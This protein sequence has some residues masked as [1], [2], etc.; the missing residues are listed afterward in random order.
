[1]RLNSQ[2]AVSQTRIKPERVTL[3]SVVY[4]PACGLSSGL[5]PDIKALFLS[6]LTQVSWLAT[7][8][9]WERNTGDSL[10][11]IST[12]GLGREHTAG[13]QTHTPAHADKQVLFKKISVRWCVA[14]MWNYK[15]CRSLILEGKHNKQTLFRPSASYC[16]YDNEF[17]MYYKYLSFIYKYVNHLKGTSF[18]SFKTFM[19]FFLEYNRR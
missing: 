10:F 3:H 8:A 11:K 5:S 2:L 7:R 12:A 18:M 16:F 13:T 9:L 14:V 1:M 17:I 15:A 19:T 6:S 4:V